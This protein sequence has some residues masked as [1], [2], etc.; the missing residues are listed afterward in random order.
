MLVAIVAGLVSR[1]DPD[2]DPAPEVPGQHLGVKAET[3][4]GITRNIRRFKPDTGDVVGPEV[5]VHDP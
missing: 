5:A 2:P 4:V 3:H 1:R